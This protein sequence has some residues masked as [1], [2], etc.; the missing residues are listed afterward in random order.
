MK[1]TEIQKKAISE[2]LNAYLK[3]HK[4]S[5]NEFVKRSEINERYISAILK[6]QII[7]GDVLI[8]DKWYKMIAEKINF[9]LKKEY[10]EVRPTP[11]MIRMLDTLQEA[12]EHSV[13]R[14]VIGETG[15]GKS[16]STELFKNKYPVN[17]YKVTVGINDTIGDL[18]DKTL[19][20]L[21]LPVLKSKSKKL[22]SIAKFLQQEQYRGV[23]S[24]MIYDESEFMKQPTL[25]NMKELSDEIEGYAGLVLVG[26]KQLLDNLETMRKKDKPGIPQFYRRVKFCIRELPAIDRNFTEFLQSI[27]DK[28]LKDWLKKNCENYGELH[29]VLVPAMREAE[30]LGEPLTL[31][32]VRKILGIQ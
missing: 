7:T 11:Q 8:A 6:G 16:K 22:N 31:S 21:R 32:L 18:L 1:L 20:A 13:T 14:I 5:A 29:D 27:E 17:T 2:E 19:E 25:C 3:E 30:R 23:L 4:I 10:W 24:T 15:C 9:S 26:T 12:R 28:D